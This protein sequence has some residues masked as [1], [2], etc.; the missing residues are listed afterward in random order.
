MMQNNDDTKM[1]GI[2]LLFLIV[3]Y[4]NYGKVHTDTVEGEI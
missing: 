3:D 4:G 1:S 2:H